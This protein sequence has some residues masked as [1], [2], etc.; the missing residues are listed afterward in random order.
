MVFVLSF[1]RL[2]AGV[3]LG[4]VLAGSAAAAP[5]LPRVG[6]K[7]FAG[8]HGVIGAV[9]INDHPV[10]TLHTSAG[11]MDPAQRALSAKRRLTDLVASGLNAGQIAARPRGRGVWAVT[12][13]GQPLLTATA[14]AAT[15]QRQSARHLAAG[16]A[17]GLKRG[18]AEPALTVSVRQLV[19]PF[20]SAKTLTVGG[21]AQAADVLVSGGDPRMVTVSYDGPTRQLVVR[22]IG[23]GA[24]EVSVK[25]G[26]VILPISVSVRKYAAF[27]QPQV[28]VRVTGR[29]NAPASLVQNALYLGLKLALNATPGAQVRVLKAPRTAGILRPG[30]SLSRRVEVRVAGA[31]LLPVV[32]A[33]LITVVNQPLP[34]VPAVALYYSNNP[35]QV[36]DSIKLFTA[37]LTPGQPIR[38]DYH[39]RT[40]AA[41]R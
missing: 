24:T 16:W 2:L 34:P 23:T 32:A 8:K 35:E 31:D 33:P 19:L 27:V 30:G 41:S 14:G 25:T 10:A 6:A 26:D 38:L 1:A 7:S 11:G 17:A 5:F 36:R 29:P 21:A 15:A 40:A 9:T 4:C 37:P 22:G 13:N 12:G 20:G 18:L 28:T 3:G 39:I